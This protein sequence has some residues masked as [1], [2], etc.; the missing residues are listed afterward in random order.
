MGPPYG[1]N[2]FSLD[3]VRSFIA[4]ITPAPDQKAISDLIK[5]L[6]Q[7]QNPAYAE[8]LIN[9]GPE[10]SNL[11]QALFTYLGISPSFEIVYPFFNL[12]M[13]NLTRDGKD[14][15]QAQITMTDY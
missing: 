1:L 9:E 10:K 12:S 15:F 14:L 6:Y 2:P 8:Q 5:V 3:I 11:H 13:K 7:I 4:A